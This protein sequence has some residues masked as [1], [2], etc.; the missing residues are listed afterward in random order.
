MLAV[1]P[2]Q[3]TNSI[4]IIIII[5]IRRFPSC[6]LV[7]SIELRRPTAG[8]P[9]ETGRLP[10]LKATCMVQLKR[11]QVR[12]DNS[13]ATRKRAQ[14]RNLHRIDKCLVPRSRCFRS[15]WLTD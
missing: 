11:S 1:W 12:N 3:A 8:W 4:P 15:W 9:A 10:W 14:L 5:I 2:V 7:H 13:C 6:S